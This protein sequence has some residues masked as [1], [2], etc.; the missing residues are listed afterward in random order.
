MGTWSPRIRLL[1]DG[2]RRAGRRIS[3]Q[4][5]EDRIDPGLAQQ[6]AGHEIHLPSL[7]DRIEDIGELLDGAMLAVQYELVSVFVS[8]FTANLKGISP[9]PASIPGFPTAFSP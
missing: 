4:R 6:V 3:W 2:P 1:R 8:L 9:F 7:R 5:A